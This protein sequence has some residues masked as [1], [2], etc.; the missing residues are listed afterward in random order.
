MIPTV[1]VSKLIQVTLNYLTMVNKLE[2][3]SLLR[4]ILI[5]GLGLIF[6]FV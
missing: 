3:F 5:V 2:D 1:H 4:L 6:T